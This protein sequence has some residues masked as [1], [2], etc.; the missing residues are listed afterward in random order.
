MTLSEICVKRPIFALMMV[1]ALV[2]FGALSFGKLGVDQFPD[3]EL[4]VVTV[5]TS[6]RGASPEEVETQITKPLEDAISTASGIDEINS[7]SLEGLSIVTVTFV[8]DR[9]RDQATQDVRDRVARVVGDLPVGTDPPVVTRFDTTAAPVLTLVVS[10]PR[11]LRE[12]T[13]LARHDVLERLQGV[14]GVGQI[15]LV[16]GRTRAFNVYLDADA[17]VS[18]GISVGQVRTAIQQQNVELPGGRVAS[19]AREEI[20]RTVARVQSADELRELVVADVQGAPLTLGQIGTVQDSEEDPRSLSRLDG[21]PAVALVVQKQAGTNTVEVVDSVLARLATLRQELPSDIR[22]DVVRDQSK[23]IRRSI[24]EVEI[25]LVLGGVL[26]SLAVLLFMGSLR[27]TFIAAVAI[28][29]S[30][31]TT[32]VVLRVL[33]YTLN[34][35][36]LLALTLAVGI[37]I[38]DAIVVLENVYRHVE[39]GESPFQAAIKGTKEIALAVSATTLSLI[40]IFIPTAFM[41]GRVGRFWR[42]FG[43]TVAFAI[44]I[45][46]FI[47]LT[48]TP[49]LCSKL[50]RPPK[51]LHGQKKR[52]LVDRLNQVLDDSYGWLVKLSLKA[53]IVIVLL[54]VATV[55]AIYPL[56]VKIGKDFVPV[57]DTSDFSIAMTMPEGS[58]LRASSETATEV[59][60]VVRGIRGVRT[61][62][63]T[64]GS[65][66]GGDDV[67]EVTMYVAIEDLEKRDYSLFEVM[68]QVRRALAPFADLRP[69]VAGVNNFGGARGGQLG[70]ALR[71]P[72][73]E[74]LQRYADEM[75]TRMRREP[76][77]VDVDTGAAVR[78]PEVRVLVDR[79]RATDLGVRA[80]ELASALRTMVG[81]EPVSK[82]RE[83][84]E[85]YDVWLRLEPADRASLE[86]LSRLPIQS[87]S[88]LVRLDTLATLLRD[89]GPA[90]I[91]RMN[92]VRQV[93]VS[94]NLVDVPLGTAIDRVRAIA[95]ELDMPAGYEVVFSGRAKIMGETIGQFFIAL[96]LSLLFMYMVLAAQFESLLHPVTILLALPLSLPFALLSLMLLDDTLNLYSTFGVFML[97]GIVKKNG[98]LQ[99]DYT[100]T[101]RAQWAEARSAGESGAS[102]AHG[103]SIDSRDERNRAII[104]ANKTRLR[105]ILMTTLTLIAGMIPIALG[106]GPGAATRASM[107]KVIIGGQAL[108]LLITLLI[109]PVAYSYFDDVG[110]VWARLRDRL[111]RRPP[112]APGSPPPAAGSEAQPGAA[113]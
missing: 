62:F 68:G 5:T 38:D 1:S 32:F 113:E 109:V 53:R 112:V 72:D 98:I 47:A 93:S 22:I 88:G 18:R 76:G 19:D 46:W 11:D 3:V 21:R 33:G 54:A 99:V 102:A 110:R 75:V 105:P 67:T 106:E 107:A 95:A 91:D 92:R 15:D 52:G 42:S 28:P 111:G 14:S 103:A 59:E 29:S 9:N 94:A 78:K 84:S 30:I 79:R 83:G 57:D 104:E 16:G 89:R 27:S 31:V 34:N 60:R 50:L 64:I 56:G 41:E 58:S 26:A 6:L 87:R 73:L 97:F 8:L 48:L 17:L 20:L 101:L 35:F 36:T 4:P 65:S 90:Q 63:T 81:G 45:S 49:M 71:G 7:T 24:H 70:F 74:A 10:S 39:R 96:G 25:H 12:L 61:I 2:V 85:Q 43:V 23:F 82:I 13:D 66:R 44:A 100:N 108:S 86:L 80:G 40:V 77:L 37:V 51:H 69:A 55:A